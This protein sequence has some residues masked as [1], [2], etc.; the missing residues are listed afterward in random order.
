[1]TVLK[2]ISSAPTAGD[3]RRPHGAR[4]P[5]A[6]VRGSE[7]DDRTATPTDSDDADRAPP[8]DGGFQWGV[9][10]DPEDKS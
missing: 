6:T 1:M 9:G 3:S 2:D 4:T 8:T 10:V 5:A 7:T